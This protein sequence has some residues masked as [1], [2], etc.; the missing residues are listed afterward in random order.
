[1][2]RPVVSTRT[3]HRW[4]SSASL[5]C[6]WPRSATY[7]TA[8]RTDLWTW[9]C[10]TATTTRWTQPWRGFCPTSRQGLERTAARTAALPA[11]RC[12][13]VRPAK[14]LRSALRL[15]SGAAQAKGVGVINASPFSMGLLTKSARLPASSGLL[16]PCPVAPNRLEKKRGMLSQC[17]PHNTRRRHRPQGPPAWHPAS[18]ATKDACRAAVEHCSAA[19]RGCDPRCRGPP[20]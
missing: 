18:E 12:P 8:R 5:P 6:R 2:R 13:F 19:G 16:G 17:P 14:Q 1:M 7:W 9:C 20:Q 10:R 11:A 15:L 3:A 4:A